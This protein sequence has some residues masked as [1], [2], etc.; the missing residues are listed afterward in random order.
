MGTIENL[1]NTDAVNKLKELAEDARICMFCTDLT[2]VPIAARPMSVKEVDQEGNLWFISGADSNKNVEIIDD[3]EVQLFFSN[4]DASEYLSVYGRA[5][6]YTDRHTI[7][8]KWS[9][10]ANA[11]FHGKDDER[12]TII[13]VQP[14]D[15]KYWDTQDG[16]FVTLLKIA[17]STLTGNTHKEGGVEGKLDV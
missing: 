6:I 2:T 1:N 15:S 13:R 17:T 4:N 16:K 11:W 9:P 5:Y 8:D 10:M 12:V 7:E 14:I 3:P